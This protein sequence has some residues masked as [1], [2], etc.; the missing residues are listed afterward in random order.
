MFEVSLDPRQAKGRSEEPFSLPVLALPHAEGY[1]G[2]VLDQ[3]AHLSGQDGPTAGAAGGEL[4]NAKLEDIEQPVQIAAQRIAP[5][6]RLHP[7]RQRSAKL[8]REPRRPVPVVQGGTCVQRPHVLRSAGRQGS[9]V[10]G[11]PF[12]AL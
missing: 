9:W 11:D 12:A 8:I 4:S 10:T 3:G 1:L 2:E 7:S 5:H 6:A